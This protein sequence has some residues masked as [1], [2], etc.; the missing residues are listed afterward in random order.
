MGGGVG[1]GQ[2][3]SSGGSNFNATQTRVTPH[4]PVW[5]RTLELPEILEWPKAANSYEAGRGNETV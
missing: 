1:E 5:G 2:A 4:H 3:E